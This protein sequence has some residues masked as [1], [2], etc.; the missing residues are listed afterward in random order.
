M[1]RENINTLDFKLKNYFDNVAIK[2][3]SEKSKFLFEL[4][5]S[6]NDRNLIIDIDK[7]FLNQNIYDINWK[8]LS[9]PND[10]T[11]FVER[12]SSGVNNLV[13]DIIEIVEKNRFDSNY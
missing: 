9:N 1:I 2:E 3:K 5:L 13:D 10:K 12:K 8:Y 6:K 7:E 11:S 4:N